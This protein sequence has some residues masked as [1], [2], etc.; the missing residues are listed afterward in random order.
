MGS[1]F[2]NSNGFSQC[3]DEVDGNHVGVKRS[4]LNISDFTNRKGKYKL[5]IEV[6]TD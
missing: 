2:Y 6:R 4:S 1:K 5:N 3:V